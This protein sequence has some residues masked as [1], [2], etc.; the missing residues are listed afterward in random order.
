MQSRTFVYRTDAARFARDLE[1]HGMDVRGPFPVTNA[2]G[3]VEHVV[4]WSDPRGTT[5]SSTEDRIAGLSGN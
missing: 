1:N 2:G 3:V 4:Y 5:P